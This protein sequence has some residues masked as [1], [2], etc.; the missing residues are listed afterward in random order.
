MAF[1][2][3]EEIFFGSGKYSSANSVSKKYFNKDSKI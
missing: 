2:Y 3:R 1:Y